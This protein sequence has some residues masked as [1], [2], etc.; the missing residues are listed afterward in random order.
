MEVT[1]KILFTIRDPYINSSKPTQSFQVQADL[2]WCDGT[3]KKYA[4][5]AEMLLRNVFKK[6]YKTALGKC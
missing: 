6:F 5:N 3:F 2:F 1:F 4:K